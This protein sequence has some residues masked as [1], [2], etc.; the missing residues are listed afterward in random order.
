MKLVNVVLARPYL[1]MSDLSSVST[2]VVPRTAR[3][4]PPSKATGVRSHLARRRVELPLRAV[5]LRDLR[6]VAWR[7]TTTTDDP[8]ASL[9]RALEG[10]LHRSPLAG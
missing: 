7:T 5:T 1:E 3:A 6:F 10:A 9:E 8:T 2:S 4:A